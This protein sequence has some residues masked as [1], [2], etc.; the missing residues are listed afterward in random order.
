MSS[1]ANEP[2]SSGDP[3]S[4]II[5]ALLRQGSHQELQRSRLSKN[6]VQQAAAKVADNPAQADNILAALFPNGIP[7]TE[8][9]YD[10][11]AEIEYRLGHHDD[12]HQ[13]DGLVW[14]RAFS[15]LPPQVGFELLNSFTGENSRSFFV[16]LYALPTLLQSI[17]LP[18]DFLAD[19][20]IAIRTRLGNDGASSGFWSGLQSLSRAFPETALEV[21]SIL[22][23]NPV[24]ENTITVAANLIGHLRA[25][26]A[27][28]SGLSGLLSRLRNHQHVDR[29][30]IYHRSWITL[31]LQRPLA[32]NEFSDAI[33]QMSLGTKEEVDEAFNVIRVLLPLEAISNESFLFGLQWLHER[34][35]GSV[36]DF[37][38]HF[39]IQLARQ[40]H[41]RWQIIGK[42]AGI[43][44]CTD[45]VLAALPIRDDRKGTW[46]ELEELLVFLL[47]NDRSV[48][49]RLL[50]D[51]AAKDSEALA[52]RFRSRDEFHEITTKLASAGGAEFVVDALLS[53]EGSIRHIGFALFEALGLAQLDD[54]RLLA[55]SD[56]RIA[57]LLFSFQLEPFYDEV[58]GRFL[59]AIEPRIRLASQRLQELLVGELVYQSKNLPGACLDALKSKVE[60]SPLVRRAV[61]ESER[62]FDTLRPCFQSAINSM[63]IPGLERAARVKAAR[64]SR[65]MRATMNKVSVFAQLCST[66]YTL[67]GGTRWQTFM[68]GR[69][70]E[71]SEMQKM[72]HSAEFPR[73]P[74]IDPE[75]IAMRRHQATLMI[76]A[77]LTAEDL[78]NANDA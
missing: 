53:D 71:V 8:S 33:D 6:T 11:L 70:G 68:E 27:S 3:V 73:M 21:A 1:N 62:Y 4:D 41:T 32:D 37:W 64:Q 43:P 18:A 19:W 77:L 22:S 30:L 28:V 63:G 7:A 54:Q 61:E 65:E 47:D 25:A 48:F 57:V 44:P 14:A 59:L 58:I 10:G 26:Q 50:L 5:A 20:I 36:S 78:R 52:K 74:G 23:S 16:G 40:L 17:S 38:K 2:V 75:G 69:L 56:D 39:V 31:G 12:L 60:E 76:R 35:T 51:L 67:Y 49:R 9:F 72:S 46:H 42:A 15:A 66:S 34:T 24:D 45:L 13:L 29:R 55:A